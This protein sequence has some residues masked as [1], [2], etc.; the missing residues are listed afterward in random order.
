ML[1]E[2]QE[3]TTKKEEVLKP[4]SV[5]P[6]AARETY[7]PVGKNELPQTEYYIEDGI[8]KSK[9]KKGIDLISY[10]KA[11]EASCDLANIVARYES[12]DVSVINVKANGVSGDVA[13]L[14]HS[15]ND[16]S[17]LSSRVES[18][19]AGLPEDIR[20]L[21]SNDPT[22]FLEAI[23][24]NSVNDIISKAAKAKEEPKEDE[25]Q[26]EENEKEGENK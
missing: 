1:N 10:L 15:I 24:D 4:W 2:V 8:K 22:K 18:S 6:R 16:I 23:L 21:F 14:P 7:T 17:E 13:S 25:P 20:A 5:K 26:K 11:S 9:P 12:G 19:F 3:P